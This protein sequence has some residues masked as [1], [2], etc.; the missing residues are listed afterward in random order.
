M[1]M[2][3]ALL[4]GDIW[5]LLAAITYTLVVYLGHPIGAVVLALKYL[6]K[7]KAPRGK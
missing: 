2:A 1:V 5:T 7:G 4:H 3:T 6:R